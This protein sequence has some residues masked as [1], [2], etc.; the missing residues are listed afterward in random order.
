MNTLKTPDT[1]FACAMLVRGAK[2]EAWEPVEDGSR[3]CW[4]LSGVKAEWQDDYRTGRDRLLAFAHQRR[5]LMNILRADGRL[6]T[7]PRG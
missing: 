4:T 2:L 3:M 5:V 6:R 7:L 1:D